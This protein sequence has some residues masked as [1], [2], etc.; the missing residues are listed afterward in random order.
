M[1][2]GEDCKLGLY[3]K[4]RVERTDGGSAPGAK[5]EN[6]QYFVLD[7]THDQFAIPALT[8]YRDACSQKFPKLAEDIDRLLRG[9]RVFTE[10]L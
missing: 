3:R 5:H 10:N 2:S 7:A 9:E 4:F 6:C 1:R 8:A